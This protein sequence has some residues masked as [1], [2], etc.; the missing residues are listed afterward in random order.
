MAGAAGALAR[1]VEIVVFAPIGAAA[2]ARERLPELAADGRERVEQRL[3]TARFVGRLVVEQGS[4][5]I[6]RRRTPAPRGTAGADVSRGDLSSAASPVRPG[7]PVAP[8]APLSSVPP[9]SP[10]SAVDEPADAADDGDRMTA[11]EL[12]IEDYESLAASQVVARLAALDPAGL[13]AIESFERAHRHRR[14]ILG[15]VAQLRAS[16]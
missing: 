1:L 16:T 12:P 7:S 10:V 2:V 6:E 11:G 3:A 9:V 15:R 8:V 5:E 13:D 14:T 4:R